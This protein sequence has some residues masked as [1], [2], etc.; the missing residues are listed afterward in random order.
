MIDMAIPADSLHQ[1]ELRQNEGPRNNSMSA[2][3]H[4]CLKWTITEDTYAVN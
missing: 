2:F 1:E 4:M 3:L